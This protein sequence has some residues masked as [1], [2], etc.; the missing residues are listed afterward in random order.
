VLQGLSEARVMIN[1]SPM[2]DGAAVDSLQTNIQ[3]DRDDAAET[4]AATPEVS[5]AV[6][7]A[8]ANQA[9]FSTRIARN[10]G[11][12]VFGTA[13][14]AKRMGHKISDVAQTAVFDRQRVT[15]KSQ[16]LA[17]NAKGILRRV[18]TKADPGVV[19]SGVAGL[20]AGAGEVMGGAVGGVV[21][22][23]VGGPPGTL[24]G[25]KVGALTGSMLGLK[26][27][28]DVALDMMKASSANQT[29]QPDSQSG[30]QM[31]R[32]GNSKTATRVGE[33]VGITSGAS[34]GSLVA[35]PVAGF[36]V[37]IVGQ[38]VGGQVGK[39]TVRTTPN[40]AA[41]LPTKPTAGGTI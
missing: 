40:P 7:P 37:G 6:K 25:T 3:P 41:S 16:Q 1:R 23:L 15:A 34:V 30:T 26:V 14:Q 20:S 32:S 18:R 9:A 33:A 13:R 39:E 27:G 5:R 28:A 35:G 22:T 38:V 12:S 31:D 36:V 24:I 19:V 11:R 21:G 4:A 17:G 2:L 8:D 29:S 10:L